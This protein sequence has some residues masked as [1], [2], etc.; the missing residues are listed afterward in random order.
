MKYKICK[1][2]IMDT[3]DPDITFDNQWISNHYY[4]AFQKVNSYPLNLNNIE[5]KNELDKQIK[6]IKEEGIWNKYD[7]LI[8]ISWWVDSTYVAY[9]AKKVWLK[10]LAFHL[11]N[12]WNSDLA[13]KNI[14]NIL[15]KLWID[16]YTEVLDWEEF[17]DLQ[18]SF[19]K[20]SVPDLEI[21]TDHAIVSW[22]Y[23]VAKKHNIKNIIIWRNYAT[24]SIWV[25]KWSD[26]HWDW[27]YIKWIQKR[28]GSKKLDTYPHM[29]LF[30]NLYYQFFQLWIKTFNLLDFIEYDK[31]KTLSLLE[32]ELWYK[33]YNLKHW[34]SIYTEFVQNLVLPEKFWY[35]KRKMHFSSLIC[36]WQ[37]TRQEALEL[38]KKPLFISKQQREELKSYVADKLWIELSYLDDL[39]KKEN[40]HYIDYPWN[41]KTI[42]YKLMLKIYNLLSK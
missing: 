35:D 13:T 28:F 22:M 14:E 37:M 1:K 3:S 26:G 31:E 12:W 20:A 38:I 9:M 25:A 36:S 16:L 2:T 19:L 24:E 21:P 6:R 27:W 10:P 34:E 42:I 33:K 39:L 23:K 30:K 4:K 8:W 29:S 7:C 32:K 40:K 11:D 5:K 41:K 17:K 18:L 15:N